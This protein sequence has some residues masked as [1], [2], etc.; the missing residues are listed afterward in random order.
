MA[1]SRGV[2]EFRG[3]VGV[4]GSWPGGF[5]PVVSGLQQRPKPLLLGLPCVRCKA[6]FAADLEVCPICGCTERALLPDA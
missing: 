4:V 3:Q 1:Q 2:N 5:N 6:Y